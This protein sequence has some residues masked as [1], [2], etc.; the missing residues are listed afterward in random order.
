[1]K[2][3]AIILLFISF[4]TLANESNLLVNSRAVQCKKI[5]FAELNTVDKNELES[6]YCGY[7]VGELV[8]EATIKAQEVKYANDPK[9]QVYLAEAR[10]N[11]LMQC[12]AP[13]TEIIDIL[14]RK[15]KGQRFECDKYK[16]FTNLAN[17]K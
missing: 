11:E 7:I 12:T 13:K 14:N 9:M 17:K 15:F 8:S 3:S 5:D 6:I 4:N 2:I 1:M 10:I 16:G